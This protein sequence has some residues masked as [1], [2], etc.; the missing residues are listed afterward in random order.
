MKYT[1]LLT[2][3]IFFL[4]G[5]VSA[6]ASVEGADELIAEQAFENFTIETIQ[7][8]FPE[9][10]NYEITYP[11]IKEPQKAAYE[12]W[13]Q[14]MRALF[15]EGI[16]EYCD[17]RPPASKETT[18]EILFISA[19]TIS[20]KVNDG[21]YCSSAP[22]PYSYTTYKNYKLSEQGLTKVE[23]TDIFDSNNKWA[24]KLQSEILV[25][26][27][28]SPLP[29]WTEDQKIYLH[30]TTR[31]YLEDYGYPAWGI[32]SQGIEFNFGYIVGYA[33]G[34]CNSEI[35]WKKLHKYL[36]VDFFEAL[37]PE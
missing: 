30:D 32:S 9:G 25:S 10:E 8:K 36:S 18:F 2:L 20:L 34:K 12:E 33:A 24:G 5:G 7:K 26:V 1:I 35:S 28:C 3:F 19:D 29:S 14:V 13:N 37:K 6:L 31:T 4:Y 21:Y 11:Q 16:D 23:L 22:H 27:Q 17:G 15:T